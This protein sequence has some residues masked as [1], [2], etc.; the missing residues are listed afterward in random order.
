MMTTITVV[1]GVVL[2]AATVVHMVVTPTVAATV[3]HMAV[4]ML[5]MA[6]VMLHT[7]A[8]THQLHLLRQ[9]LQQ[10]PLKATKFN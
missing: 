2:M 10:H 3:L 4:A 6:V 8:V 1:V 9:Q 7:V 5:L